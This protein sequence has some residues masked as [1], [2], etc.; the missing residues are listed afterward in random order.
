MDDGPRDERGALEMLRVAEGEGITTVIATPHAHHADP[1]LVPAAVKVLN[2]LAEREGIGVTILP[3]SE[4]RIAADLLERRAEGRL[5]TL[6]GSDYLLLELYLSRSQ[7]WRVEV[8]LSVIDRL[9]DAGL[10]PVLAH[11]E[12]YPFVVRDPAAITP[13]V[14]RGVLAQLNAPS[15]TGYHGKSAQVTARELLARDLVHL[16]AS[17]AHNPQWRPPRLREAY[18]EVTRL[19]GAARTGWIMDVAATIASGADLPGRRA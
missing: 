9:L 18:E 8:V 2:E 12:R 11:P 15:L 3:G 6:N 7:E 13:L 17:D 5:L 14:E 19:A 4:V 1:L 10:R 16:I